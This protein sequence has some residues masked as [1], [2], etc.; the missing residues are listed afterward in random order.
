M[1]VA[2]GIPGPLNRDGSQGFP[3]CH[4]P[5][6]SGDLGLVGSP[7]SAQPELFSFVDRFGDWEEK[8]GADRDDDHQRAECQSK[9]TG[10][11]GSHRWISM[12]ACRSSFYRSD[13]T[14][15]RGELA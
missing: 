8:Q 13:G 7:E 2:V 11:R 1:G 4:P 6:L 3:P 14:D 15:R 9:L 5:E 10:R 12:A